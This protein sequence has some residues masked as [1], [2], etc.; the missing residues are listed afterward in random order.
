MPLRLSLPGYPEPSC[1]DSGAC[2]TAVSLT[3]LQVGAVLHDTNRLFPLAGHCRSWALAYR[4]CLHL[5]LQGLLGFCRL[6]LQRQGLL[7]S[8]LL[9]SSLLL[10]RKSLSP[11]LLLLRGL[12]FLLVPQLLF[13]FRLFVGLLPVVD[14]QTLHHLPLLLVELVRG[15]RRG[16]ASLLRLGIVVRVRVGHV[17]AGARGS[18]RRRGWG[19]LL[20]LLGRRVGGAGGGALLPLLAHGCVRRAMNTPRP[21]KP[22]GLA[23][24]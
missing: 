3:N 15:T 2:T 8:G 12:L 4:R 13:L 1:S 5:R 7:G 9:S 24:T 18:L 10:L 16:D 19:R 23:A 17:E 11:L 21:G 6:G 14:L 20:L 22:W